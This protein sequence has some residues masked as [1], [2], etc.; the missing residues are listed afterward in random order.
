MTIGQTIDG[1]VL[2]L[3]GFG[4]VVDPVEEGPGA[5]I[6]ERRESEDGDVLG[7][8]TVLSRLAVGAMS[9]KPIR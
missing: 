6:G 4:V 7:S 1:P 8:A 3:Q 5:P 9:A 2:R